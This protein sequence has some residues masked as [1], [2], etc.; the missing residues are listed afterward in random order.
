MLTVYLHCNIW[1]TLCIFLF[2][3]MTR[4]MDKTILRIYVAEVGSTNATAIRKSYLTDVII[5][6]SII[7]LRRYFYAAATF[8]F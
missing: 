5:T 7:I 6:K 8:V 1:Q 2:I 3:L 4:H